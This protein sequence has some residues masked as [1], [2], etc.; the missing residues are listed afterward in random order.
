ME[1]LFPAVSGVDVSDAD[2]T[3]PL[4][5]MSGK[6]LFFIQ[7]EADEVFSSAEVQNMVTLASRD[8]RNKASSWIVS[9]GGHLR[10][11]SYDAESYFAKIDEFLDTAFGKTE[12]TV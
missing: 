11:R 12:E 3:V 10:N 8:G 5:K 7:G 9:G 1:W 4:T 6:H 2:L